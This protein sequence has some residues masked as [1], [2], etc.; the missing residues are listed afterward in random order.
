M[1]S[2]ETIALAVLMAAL[3]AGAYAKPFELDPEYRASPL[4]V[5]GSYLCRSERGVSH[6]IDF[7]ADRT[8]AMTD[9]AAGG[10]IFRLGADGSFEW[11]SGPL[12]PSDGD[13]VA[14]LGMNAERVAD[15]EPVIVLLY[16]M[17]GVGSRDHCFRQD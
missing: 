17:P 8:Y 10:G 14:I 16:D 4:L 12:A 13:A 9:L 6:S 7:S 5:A 2:V 3:P 1:R 11:L 15:G